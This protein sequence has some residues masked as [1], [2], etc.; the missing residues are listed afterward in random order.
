VGGECVTRA[1][2]EVD[3]SNLGTDVYARL[4]DHNP[5]DTRLCADLRL[6]AGQPKSLRWGGHPSYKADGYWVH[7]RLALLGLLV[8]IPGP[9]HLPKHLSSPR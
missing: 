5:Q 8:V 6:A 2:L 4:S 7:H 9:K 1:W 3:T